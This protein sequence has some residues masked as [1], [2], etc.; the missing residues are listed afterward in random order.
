LTLL[1]PFFIAIFYPRAFIMFLSVAG[2]CTVLLQA[3]MPA[4]MAW[5]LR[6]TRKQTMQ[7]QVSG[8]KPALIL[9]MTVSVI[10][11]LVSLYHFM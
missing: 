5:N 11:M 1:P 7:Y 8:G 4:M 6:Y 9:S 2:F 10:I 3:L